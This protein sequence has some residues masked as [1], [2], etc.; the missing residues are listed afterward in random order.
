MI[1]NFRTLYLFSCRQHKTDNTHTQS[2]R[3]TSHLEARAI[4]GNDHKQATDITRL[5]ESDPNTAYLPKSNPSQWKRLRQAFSQPSPTVAKHYI[6]Y[7]TEQVSALYTW[8]D[9]RCSE[10]FLASLPKPDSH[11]R[12]SAGHGCATLLWLARNKPE[13]VAEYDAAGTVQDLVV[14]MITGLE[15]PV[16]SAQNAAGWGYFDTETRTWNIDR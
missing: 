9:G 10:E 16:M 2:Y 5:P 8:Q 15:R 13:L 14:S 7:E 1:P 6:R 4:S 3:S 12:L 11:L